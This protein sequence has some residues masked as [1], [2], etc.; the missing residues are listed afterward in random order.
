MQV[1][2]ILR[3]SRSRSSRNFSRM[4]STRPSH[5]AGI[6]AGCKPLR[7]HRDRK[8]QPAIALRD[9]GV[10]LITGGLGGMGLVLAES[11]AKS[12]RA[13]LVLV[14]RSAFPATESWDEWLNTS[15]RSG[16]DHSTN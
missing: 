15:R 6:G 4:K 13:R 10:Y 7:E 5:I 12:V 14:G 16:S 3:S 9:K 1:T 8:N 2:T 11:I